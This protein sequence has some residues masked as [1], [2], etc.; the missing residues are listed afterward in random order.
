MLVADH[1]LTRQEATQKVLAD[2]G[3]GQTLRGLEVLRLISQHQD[4]HRLEKQ[5]LKLFLKMVE[6]TALIMSM[7]PHNPLLKVTILQKHQHRRYLRTSQ[8]RRRMEGMTN[9]PSHWRMRT[10]PHRHLVVRGPEVSQRRA[11]GVEAGVSQVR[12]QDRHLGLKAAQDLKADLGPKVA[13][14]LRT[15][16]S[17]ALNQVQDLAPGLILDPNPAQDPNPGPSLAPGRD[18]NHALDQN[19]DQNPVQSQG[20]GPEQDQD[21]DHLLEADHDQG[22]GLAA[23]LRIKRS[24]W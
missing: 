9:Q 6:E 5:Q 7:I 19:P 23:T 14:N 13:L 11:V 22:Q 24:K 4:I 8:Q 16:P 20:P 10:S 21:L 3:P 2:Q 18:L 17:P 12:G 1:V 15:D